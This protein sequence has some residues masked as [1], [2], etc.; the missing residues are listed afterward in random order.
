MPL[1]VDVSCLQQSVLWTNLCVLRYSAATELC[2]P[3]SL[4]LLPS[5]LLIISGLSYQPPFR[6]QVVPCPLCM[7]CDAGVCSLR[8]LTGAS[9]RIYHI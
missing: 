6:T 5:V 3:L 8:M 2:S 7:G 4:R 1:C 9:Y